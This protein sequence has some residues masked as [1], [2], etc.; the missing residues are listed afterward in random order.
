VCFVYANNQPIEPPTTG[1]HTTDK[2]P[3]PPPVYHPKEHGCLCYLYFGTVKGEGK[4][5]GNGE[6]TGK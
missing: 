2:V 6:R 5:P 3:P 1:P 4:W